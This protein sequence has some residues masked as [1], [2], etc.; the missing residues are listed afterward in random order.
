M[1]TPAEPGQAPVRRDR[2]RKGR[3]VLESNYHEA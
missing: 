1:E 3:S 2:K